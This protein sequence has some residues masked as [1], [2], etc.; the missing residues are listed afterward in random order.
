MVQIKDEP[1]DFELVDREPENEVEDNY[2]RYQSIRDQIGILWND[3]NDVKPKIEQVDDRNCKQEINLSD[4]ILSKECDLE[5]SKIME[6]TETSASG[7][8]HKCHPAESISAYRMMEMDATASIKKFTTIQKSKLVDD[9]RSHTGEKLFTCKFCME[10]FARKDY[11][12]NHE[13]THSSLFAFRCSK[14]GHGFNQEVAKNSHESKCKRQ[15]YECNE[16]DY[17]TYTSTSIRKHTQTHNKLFKCSICSKAFALDKSLRDHTRTHTKE[18]PFD[19]SKCDERFIEESEKKTHEHQ[20]NGRRFECYVYKYKCYK[21]RD[22]I[23]HMQSNQCSKRTR[24]FC[25][26]ECGK[27][28]S[29]KTHLKLHL[30]T[31]HVKRSINK[32]NSQH[33]T[34]LHREVKSI[35]VRAFISQ[36]ESV[37]IPK[38][39]TN[40]VNG[41]TQKNEEKKSNGIA[42]NKAISRK[43]KC[44]SNDITTL[45]NSK[46]VDDA[47]SHTAEKPFTCKV[48]YKSFAIKKYLRRHEKT[49]GVLFAFR[50]S[51]CGE[52]FD[53]EVAKKSHESKCRGQK[54]ECN[55]CNYT[56]HIST[57]IKKHMRTH[58][59][60]RLFKCLVCSKAFIQNIHLRS[61]TRIHVKELPFACSKCASRFTEECEKNAHELRCNI[62]R[63][64]CYVCKFKCYKKKICYVTCDQISAAGAHDHLNVMG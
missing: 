23:C 52:G 21:K 7:E 5:Q 19:C 15:K 6:N 62:R 3:V 54:Y 13:Y 28:F 64:E 32:V 20:C 41:A 1:D 26:T 36:R 30:A 60:E 44:D 37:R 38:Q 12:K 31:E 61:H 2:Y 17:I 50:C 58:N 48:C 42:P 18:L 46:L 45:H 53:H 63:Y 4:D 40:N 8:Q 29:F 34:K 10:S 39:I 22:L 47:R 56:T 55:E 51:K 33:K 43:Y 24:S 49:H 11:L 16:C 14:C 27:A 59:E 57:D 35:K 9:T 25:C